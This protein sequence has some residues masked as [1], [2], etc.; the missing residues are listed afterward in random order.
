LTD[1]EEIICTFDE[2]PGMGGYCQ[3]TLH[4]DLIYLQ[5]GKWRTEDMHPEGIGTLYALILEP[6]EG[7]EDTYKRVG[8]AEIPE[9]NG[10]A[11][12]WPIKTVT[13]I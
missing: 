2:P 8:I 3:D 11:D 6:V 10:E 12:R 4:P 1:P 9:E 5:I 7:S 13:I